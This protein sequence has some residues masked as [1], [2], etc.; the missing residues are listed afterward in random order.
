MRFDF[1]FMQPISTFAFNFI[2][3]QCLGL[4]DMLSANQ[5]AEIVHVYVHAGL[6]NSPIYDLAN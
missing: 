1:I 3:L 5:H 4:I 2:F 6:F